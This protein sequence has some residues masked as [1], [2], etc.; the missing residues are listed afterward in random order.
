MSGFVGLEEDSATGRSSCVDSTGCSSG[1]TVVVA[2][3]GIGGD[4]GRTSFDILDGLEHSLITPSPYR[5]VTEIPHPA[6]NRYSSFQA[7]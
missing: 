7:S 6:S 2:G 4:C 3:G 5:Q 1:K